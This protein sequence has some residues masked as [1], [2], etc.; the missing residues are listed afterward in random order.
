LPTRPEGV[1]TTYRPQPRG[2]G[3]ISTFF[4]YKNGS[5][6]SGALW[7]ELDVEALGKSE[8]NVLASL[9]EA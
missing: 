2:S 7:E 6:A 5:E 3:L 8:V 1:C 4:T 9:V